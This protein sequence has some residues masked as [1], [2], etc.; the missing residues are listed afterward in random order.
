VNGKLLIT[1]LILAGGQGKRMGGQDKGLVVYAGKPLVDRA[2]ERLAPQ[3]DELLISAN[4]NLEL[5]AARGYPV[6]TD[7]LPD[8]QGPLAGILVGLNAAK[9]DW[10]LTI[11]CDIPY[12][13][14]NLA[15]RLA[16]ES[17]GR[18]AVFARD[19]ERNHPAILLLNKSCLPELVD[20][21][22][23]GERSI[24]GFLKKLDAG[25]AG[26]SDAAAFRNIN[27]SRQLHG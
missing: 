3:V 5:Y 7:A 2:I 21:L 11:P 13:P 9:H 25:S 12:L 27:E 24:K 26:F 4:R 19:A 10:M 18:V 6:V 23:K 20:Y 16:G 17:T 8:Y 14:L 1:G 15:S 22:D